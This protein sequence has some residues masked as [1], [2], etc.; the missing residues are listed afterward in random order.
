MNYIK[1]LIFNEA[2]SCTGKG[3]L[4]VINYKGLEDSHISPLAIPLS[5]AL[6]S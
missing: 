1:Y 3:S 6:L 4:A 5:L 2:V